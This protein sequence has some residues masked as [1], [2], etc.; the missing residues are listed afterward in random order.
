MKRKK[1][2]EG[3]NEGNA[4]ASNPTN[5]IKATLI[6]SRENVIMPFKYTDLLII[7]RIRGILS[8]FYKFVP[9]PGKGGLWTPLKR[10]RGR[11]LE[12]S[13]SGLCSPNRSFICNCGDGRGGLKE[14][15]N[16]SRG[17]IALSR[18][19]QGSGE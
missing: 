4:N 13:S 6:T 9:F 11:T 5:K 8:S 1:G 16:T 2:I 3:H 17:R 14:T 19:W 18:W 7:F 12:G 15:G 10:S